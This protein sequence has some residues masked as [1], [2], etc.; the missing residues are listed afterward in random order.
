[1]KLTLEVSDNVIKR[2][3]AVAGL[4]DPASI[5]AFVHR[6]IQSELRRAECHRVTRADHPELAA[7]AKQVQRL[8]K[9]QRAIVALVDS[10]AAVLTTLLRG[11]GVRR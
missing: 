6:A 4:E 10:S 3:H 1:L 2:V 7:L 11:R 5:K 9:G 8:E